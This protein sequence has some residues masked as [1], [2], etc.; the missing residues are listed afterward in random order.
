MGSKL[1]KSPPLTEQQKQQIIVLQNERKSN[2]EIK[3]ITGIRDGR[4]IANVRHFPSLK[5]KNQE[6]NNP[7]PLKPDKPKIPPVEPG[8]KIDNVKKEE[9]GGSEMLEQKD[10]D[11]ILETVNKKINEVLPETVEKGIVAMS[12]KIAADIEAIRKQTEN[13]LK[14]DAER[15][16]GQKKLDENLAQIPE[17]SK[18]VKT[19]EEQFKALSTKPKPDEVET[20]DKGKGIFGTMHETYEEFFNCPEC[21]SKLKDIIKKYGSQQVMTEMCGD[22]KMCQVAVEKLSDKGYKIAVPAVEPTE[23]EKKKKELAERA[24]AIGLGEDATEEEIIKKEGEDNGESKEKEAEE[25][26]SIF[27]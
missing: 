24:K 15:L 3:A 2:E 23:E 4:L 20:H 7:P 6:E 26:G 14:K 18:Q 9:K 10:L 21:V 17:L 16:A 19:L 11:K 12:G 22:D 8:E 27:S 5:R 1:P 25:K 13:Q